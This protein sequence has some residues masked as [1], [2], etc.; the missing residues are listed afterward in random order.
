[1]KTSFLHPVLDTLSSRCAK[2]TVVCVTELDR[3]EG[4]YQLS[5]AYNCFQ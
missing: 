4:S 1:M 5:H 3:E 2:K